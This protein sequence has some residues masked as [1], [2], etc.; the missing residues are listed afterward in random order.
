MKTV[1]GILPGRFAPE[2]QSSPILQLPCRVRR[3]PRAEGFADQTLLRQFV[4]ERDG[5]AFETLLRRH[6]AMV[7]D[8]RRG[9]LGNEADVEDAFQ[10]T[11][12][13]LARRAASIR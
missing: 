2:P 12:V 1:G 9:E 13:I 8:V 3:D 4:D 7:L 11:F 5:A 6:G 10:A